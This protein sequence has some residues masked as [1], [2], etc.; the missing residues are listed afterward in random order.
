MSKEFAVLD[1]TS[2][3]GAFYIALL[4]LL[5]SYLVRT[6]LVR[7]GWWLADR[8][9]KLDMTLPVHVIV[10]VCIGCAITMVL[11]AALLLLV[12]HERAALHAHGASPGVAQA[13]HGRALG[14]AADPP[15]DGHR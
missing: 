6:Y 12:A 3:L 2:F 4:V 9:K 8:V 1:P 14:V 7:A 11:A 15:H 5:V 10:C 13:P